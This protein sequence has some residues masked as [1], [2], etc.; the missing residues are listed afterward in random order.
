MLSD[1]DVKKLDYC[2]EIFG[3][4][5]AEIIR[6]G[7]DKT[8]EEAQ[9]RVKIEIDIKYPKENFCQKSSDLYFINK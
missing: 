9:K 6:Q 7:I 1:T 2:S 8:Y 5:K 4:S 3:F